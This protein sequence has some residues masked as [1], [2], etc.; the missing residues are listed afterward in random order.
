MRQAPGVERQ[1][2]TNHSERHTQNVNAGGMA[3]NEKKM[4]KEEAER[5]AANPNLSFAARAKLARERE[6]RSVKAVTV[7]S[8][9]ALVFGNEARLMFHGVE[10]ISAGTCP[11]DLKMARPGRLQMVL[12]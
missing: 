2:G 7:K 8:G 12:K 6:Q 4:S 11:P 9:D 5:E 3:G 1:K 10:E